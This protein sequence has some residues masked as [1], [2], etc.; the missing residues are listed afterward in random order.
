MAGDEAVRTALAEEAE[1][2]A[3]QA[4]WLDETFVEIII[5]EAQNEVKDF[6][7]WGF[8]IIPHRAPNEAGL[9]DCGRRAR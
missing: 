4:A 3:A 1:E 9:R 5:S 6:A 7:K 8:D 2:F